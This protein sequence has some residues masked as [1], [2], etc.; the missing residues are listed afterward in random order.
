MFNVTIRF[1]VLA[2][3]VFIAACSHAGSAIPYTG[4]PTIEKPRSLLPASRPSGVHISINIPSTTPIGVHARPGYISPATKSISIS[5]KPKHGAALTFNADLTPQKNKHCTTGSPV[6]CSYNID[7]AP[8]TYVADFE[9]FDAL[10]KKG[11]PVGHALSSNK[12]VAVKVRKGK[13]AHLNV[14][15]GGIAASVELQ[16][17]NDVT[18]AANGSAFN[19]IGKQPQ[20]FALVVKDAD[21]NV[22]LGAGVPTA[23][24]STAPANTTLSTPLPGS[25]VWALTSHYTSTNPT[26]P[27]SVS[28]A[29]KATPV[30][31]SAAGTLSATIPL[32]LYEP[33]I[34]VV[35]NTSTGSVVAFDE[36]GNAR[37]LSGTFSGVTSP[38]FA[39]Y[40]PVTHWIYVD[41]CSNN[42]I[43]AYD[44]MGSSV[45]PSGT[46]PNVACAGQL[47]IANNLIY[48]ANWTS[49]P[50]T[51]A[52]NVYDLQGNQQTI[53]GTP[54][55]D[56]GSEGWSLAYDTNNSLLYFGDY[57]GSLAYVFN[58]AGATQTTT[59]TFPSLH[60]P[61]AAAFDPDNDL[62]YVVNQPG[63]TNV[64]VY[65]EQGNKNAALSGA[66]GLTYAAGIAYDPYN[67]MLYVSDHT[68]NKIYEFDNQGNAQ[69][70]SGAFTAGLS[71]AW[72]VLVVP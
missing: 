71:S 29:V 24:V 33:W 72:G 44:V 30:P 35:D 45:M 59:G 18:M 34:Y 23:S 51:T 9:T 14:T 5:I 65:D 69:T 39:V 28:L 43:F 7:L 60:E 36:D 46:F 6:K 54:F 1:A 48:L 27:A 58:A 63:A 47:A 15:L 52:V 37:S 40:S 19:I 62:L 3:V 10:L 41:S 66:W 68:T 55:L 50:S 2:S 42:S 38:Y 11:Q 17:M 20:R 67:G 64:T 8:G 61:N 4:L 49:T 56:A 26:V 22:M 57:G 70:T 13:Y 32:F 31:H 21:G 25:N 53:T 16:P 12:S